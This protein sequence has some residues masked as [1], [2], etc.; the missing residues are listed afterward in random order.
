MLK[1]APEKHSR[2]VAKAITYR[3]L[4]M[5]VDALVAFFITKDIAITIGIVVLVNGYS[6]ILYYLHERIWVHI[7]WGKREV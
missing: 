3:I 6:T 7:K 1:P 2:S 4:H 5:A